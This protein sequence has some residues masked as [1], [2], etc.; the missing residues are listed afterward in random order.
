MIAERIDQLN[1]AIGAVFRWCALG[2]VL[3]ISFTVLQRYA[4]NSSAIWQQE[5]AQYLHAAMFM[6][7]AGLTLKR[8]EHVRVDVF[9]EGFSERQK[10]WVSVFGTTLFLWPV[11]AALLYFSYGYV[12]ESWRILEV[13]RESGGLPFVYLLKSFIWVFAL[14]LAL[15]GLAQ[16]TKA[17]RVLRK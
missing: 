13:S 2:M 11:C 3:I 12:L 4:F 16:V 15:Q 5:L 9:Y 1:E 17:W 7:V 10:A 8:R 6:A 14:T